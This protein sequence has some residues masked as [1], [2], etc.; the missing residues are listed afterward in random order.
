MNFLLR[1][2]FCLSLFFTT[3]AWPMLAVAESENLATTG[4]AQVEL[5]GEDMFQLLLAEVATARKALPLAATLY[6]DLS[7]RHNDVELLERAVILNQSIFNYPAMRAQAQR[8]VELRPAEPRAYSALAIAQLAA[9]DVNDSSVTLAG[10]LAQDPA[11]DLSLILSVV[12]DLDLTQVTALEQLLRELS[13]THGKSASLY[14]TR[15]YLAYAL[16][17]PDDA[18]AMVDSS[19]K[20]ADDLPVSLFKFQLLL[21]NEDINQAERLLRRLARNHDNNRQVALQQINFIFR[22]RPDEMASLDALFTRFAADPAI[23]RAYARA[24]FESSF[25]ERSE[26]GFQQLLEAGFADEAQYFLGRID[27]ATGQTEDA[28]DHFAAVLNAPYLISA[29]AEWSS[30]GRAEDETRLMA[31]IDNSK[32]Q[33]PNLSPTLWR[34]Q[35]SYY[36]M[37]AQPQKAWALLQDA[38]T[39]FPTNDDLLYDQAM[40]APML[41]KYDVLEDNLSAI[42]AR[43]PDN[44]DA[45]NALGYTWADLNKNLDQAAAYI[46]LALAAEPDNP[47]FQD[48]KGWVLY[49]IGQLDDALLWLEKAYAQFENDEVAAHLA[50]VLWFLDR[51]EEARSYL[52]AIE[53]LNP[54]SQ[55]IETLNELFMQ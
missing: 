33:Q 10:W 27:L 6:A 3:L 32:L 5:T 14:Y 18:L 35:A 29:L 13:T 26:E 34:L 47:A 11:A 54:D 40:L 41:N 2:F 9:G 30:L 23:A 16:Q 31:A 36:Q 24:A 19:L 48:S 52:A 25:F 45:L 50:E 15:A 4:V 43:Q 42:L 46:D 38:T 44:I 37:R 20:L 21:A 1:P 49:R 28:I 17:R 7:A 39:Q 12:E 53:R 22:Y 8:W 55:Y 51:R